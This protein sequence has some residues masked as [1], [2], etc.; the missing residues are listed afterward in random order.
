VEPIEGI[1]K[2]RAAIADCVEKRERSPQPLPIGRTANM[3]CVRAHPN[4]DDLQKEMRL[5]PLMERLYRYL[6]NTP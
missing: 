5:A 4:A 2:S 1:V 3:P 6:P